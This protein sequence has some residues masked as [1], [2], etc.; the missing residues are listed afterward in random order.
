MPFQLI[1]T[2]SYQKRAHKFFKKH[3]E[4]LSQY[5]K[6]LQ[7][8]ELNPFHNSLR[9]HKL[10]GSLQLLHSVSINMQYR[11]TLQIL[12]QD[13]R[14]LLVNVGDHDQVY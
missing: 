3:P 8:L 10:K 9:L 6:V 7:L 11:I 2:E 12:I 14:I 5:T 13:E 4:L 1:F